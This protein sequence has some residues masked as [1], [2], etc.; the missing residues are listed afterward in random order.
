MSYT[1]VC[2]MRPPM[3]GTIPKNGLKDIIYPPDGIDTVIIHGHEVN[4]WGT[5]IYDRPLTDR[6]LSDYELVRKGVADV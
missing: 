5:V 4:N 1:Y 6:E 2:R 3:P